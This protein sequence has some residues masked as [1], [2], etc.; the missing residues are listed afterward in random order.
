MTKNTSVIRGM[1]RQ[2]L[3]CMYLAYHELESVIIIIVVIIIITIYIIYYYYYD[4]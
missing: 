2:D 4:C 3:S 1:E